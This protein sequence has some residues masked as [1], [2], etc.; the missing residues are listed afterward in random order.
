M[1]IT[2]VTWGET[3]PHPNKSYASLRPEF[4]CELNEGETVEQAIE[5]LKMKCREAV[6]LALEIE[7]SQQRQEQ[8]E[9]DLKRRAERIKGEFTQAKELWQ[10]ASGEYERLLNILSNAGVDV[11]SYPNFKHIRWPEFSEV[12]GSLDE[13]PVDEDSHETS[14][15]DAQGESYLDGY[16]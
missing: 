11:D 2:K 15:P 3:I 7:G 5:F 14:P 16:F 9:K 8:Q 6:T 12:Y 4:E 1:K 13:V 10:I